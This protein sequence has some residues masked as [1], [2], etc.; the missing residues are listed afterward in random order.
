MS[1]SRAPISTL[2]Q[3]VLEVAALGRVRINWR[4]DYRAYALPEHLEIWIPRIRSEK[5]YCTA[6]HELGH[7]LGRHQESR[8]VL[9]V[10]RWAWRWAKNNALFWTEVMD[11]EMARSLS[12]YE[13]RSP[14]PPRIV[15]GPPGCQVE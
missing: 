11:R 8:S 15:N 3:H 13:V 6:L 4:N 5:T 2:V 10:E 12:W 1:T 14:W 9:T 7:C